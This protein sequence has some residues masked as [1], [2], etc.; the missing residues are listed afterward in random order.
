MDEFVGTAKLLEP[1]LENQGQAY[2]DLRWRQDPEDSF[3]DWTIEVSFES[4][5][6]H[7]HVHRNIL[8][9][10]ARKGRYFEGLFKTPLD[11][12]EHRSRISIIPLDVPS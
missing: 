3:S 7:Y 5:V 8:G 4:S 1:D 2:E 12:Q 6:L 11:V 10:G 9:S